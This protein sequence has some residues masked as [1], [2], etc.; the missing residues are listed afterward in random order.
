[1]DIL[2]HT[3]S[4][5]A[6]GTVLASFSK[7]GFK[8]KASIILISG[9]GGAI[10]DIDA[11][12]MW[13]KFDSTIGS[14]FNLT[15]SGGQIYMGKWWYSHHGALHSLT[16]AFVLPF[17]FVFIKSITSLKNGLLQSFRQT[18]NSKKLNITGF[19]I[20]FGIHLLEDMPTPAAYWGGVNLFWP[21]ETYV[22]GFGK[23][24]WW[25][26][27][28]IFLI[29]ISVIIINL[30]VLGISKWINS[31]KATLIIF[32]LGFSLT[33]YQMNS[34]YFD[35]NYTGGA[36]HYQ[37]YEQKSKEIQKEILGPKVYSI[38]EN[39]DNSMNLNF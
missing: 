14:F 4:G 33:L 15:H 12:T 18:I 34:R 25:N 39:F 35:F 27:Y 36:K 11:I 10:P 1:M 24:W 28:D 16:M 6:V 13:S 21:S 31:Q 29:I 5:I 2:S 9:F 38:M 37:Q 17:L 7:G 23:I 22:G 26:N 19:I 30:I 32:T 20:G 3:F 8:T